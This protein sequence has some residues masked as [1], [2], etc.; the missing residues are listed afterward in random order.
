[1]SDNPYINCSCCSGTG[2]VKMLGGDNARCGHCRGLGYMLRDDIAG[3]IT[4]NV[5]KEKRKYTRRD[6][7]DKRAVLHV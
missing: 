6:R 5:V 4:E 2:N 1:M 7:I 3:S